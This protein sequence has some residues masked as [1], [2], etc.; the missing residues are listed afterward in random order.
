MDSIGE[1]ALSDKI[2]VGISLDGRASRELL[3]WAVG[4]A[5]HQSDT[6]VALHVLGWFRSIYPAK[7][8]SYFVFKMPA[9]MNSV[10]VRMLARLL[11]H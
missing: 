8:R 5:A 1:C 6:I 2:L 9:S 10:A 7:S 11:V 4:N 3:S